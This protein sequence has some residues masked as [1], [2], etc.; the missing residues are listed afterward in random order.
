[1]TEAVVKNYEVYKSVQTKEEYFGRWD[2]ESLK[3]IS[4]S[5][6]DELYSRYLVKCEVFQR[7]N[8]ECQNIGCLGVNNKLTFHHIKFK[9]NGGEDKARNGITLCETCH[10]GF[11]NGKNDLTFENEDRLPPHIR[12][13]TFK[14][15]MEEKVD[16]KQ[17]RKT[18]RQL[19]KTLKVEGK[20]YSVQWNEI[21]LL[22]AW[23][24]TDYEE[25][26]DHEELQGEL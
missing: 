4:V 11:H 20:R 5:L 9:K 7:D 22:L 21:S 12:G 16:W 18:M 26:I 2:E 3:T 24:Y 19:R 1:M 23:L 25:D 13:K 14:Y 15:W 6:M 17:F 10:R 8:F